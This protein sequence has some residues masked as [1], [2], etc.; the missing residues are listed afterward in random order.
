MAKFKIT[1]TNSTSGGYGQG[2][3][4]VDAYISSGLPDGAH[5]GGTGGNTSI[6]G[7]QIQPAV[8]IGTN[9]A[10]AGSIQSKIGRA[11][12]RVNDGTNVGDCRLVNAPQA[13]LTTNTMSIQVNSTLLGSANVTAA[14]NN[15]T[16][17]TFAYLTFATAN[18]AGPLTATAATSLGYTVTNTGLVGN[19][20]IASIST[21]GGLTTA[22]LSFASQTV[23]NVTATNMNMSFYASRITN[24]YVSDYAGATNLSTNISGGYNPNKYRYRLAAPNADF[25]QVVSA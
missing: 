13:N 19:V 16:P 10:A 17:V 20:T 12:F 9:A 7:N 24:K 6:A 22:N 3:T 11:Q 18:V 4:L 1:K 23:S 5:Y 25:V 2:T 21:T 8:K 15:T 14:V